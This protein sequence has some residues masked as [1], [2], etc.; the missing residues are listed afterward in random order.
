MRSRPAKLQL[1]Q[2]EAS[3]P[4]LRYRCSMSM[5]ILLPVY[6][7]Q[8]EGGRT[9]NTF[10][11]MQHDAVQYENGSEFGRGRR[12]LMDTH[13]AFRQR[14]KDYSAKVL[15]QRTEPS[16]AILHVHYEWTD[17]TGRRQVVP[18]LHVLHWAGKLI[19]REDFWVEEML[20]EK[21]RE[22]FPA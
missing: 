2:A 10:G 16:R 18:G 3:R 9:L 5:E 12:A 11:L 20:E 1:S 15:N 22:Y 8:L 19:N 21:L 13:R 4:N 17:E 6:I 14:V 7:N